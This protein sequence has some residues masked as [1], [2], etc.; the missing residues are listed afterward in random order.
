MVGTILATL[1]ATF[2]LAA[3]LLVSCHLKRKGKKLKKKAKGSFQLFIFIGAFKNSYV[4]ENLNEDICTHLI[5]MYNF[6]S[7]I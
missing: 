5:L 7:N 6:R 4:P 1:P 3:W 2:I